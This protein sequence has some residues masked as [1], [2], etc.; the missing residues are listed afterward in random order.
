MTTTAINTEKVLSSQLSLTQ[1]RG[2]KNEVEHLFKPVLNNKWTGTYEQRVGNEK[3]KTSFSN[4]DMEASLRNVLAA[5]ET[6]MQPEYYHLIKKRSLTGLNKLLNRKENMASYLSAAYLYQRELGS[7]DSR[8]SLNPSIIRELTNHL[9]E[10]LNNYYLLD[11][12]AL[13]KVDG[14]EATIGEHRLFVDLA[15]KRT[16]KTE[17]VVKPGKIQNGRLVMVTD[18]K[19]E[20]GE[21][22]PAPNDQFKLSITHIEHSIQTDPSGI[23]ESYW[24][25]L[26][27]PFPFDV[28]FSGIS[29]PSREHPDDPVALSHRFVYDRYKDN[30]LEGAWSYHL[31]FKYAPKEDDDLYLTIQDDMDVNKFSGS[32][33]D[34]KRLDLSAVAYLSEAIDLY[35]EKEP[36]KIIDKLLKTELFLDK[37]KAMMQPLVDPIRFRYSENNKGW[38][39]YN[40]QWI[41]EE[42]YDDLGRRVDGR[43]TIRNSEDQRLT[44]FG[45]FQSVF[46]TIQVIQ[47]NDFGDNFRFQTDIVEFPGH[48]VPNLD[49][50][51]IE[52]TDE[53][54][55]RTLSG[56]D[57][58]SQI[59][60]TQQKMGSYTVIERMSYIKNG[61][62]HLLNGREIWSGPISEYVTDFEAGDYY[63]IIHFISSRD[64]FEEIF[65]VDF[66]HGD[67]E[68]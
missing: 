58:L 23:E 14:S 62:K 1:E 30:P 39:S 35:R 61:V 8:P 15:D 66:I 12:A 11:G 41:I 24:I 38:I 45:G 18:M 63:K 43:W 25:Q 55:I 46:S 53:N 2:I 5:Y 34:N 60:T 44:V 36:E 54:V 56:T 20:R 21:V 31:D 6:F 33:A 50:I 37:Y 19:N 16:S 52:D 17:I 3:V 22:D 29:R 7:T 28:K 48:V 64:G 57:V 68:K 65:Q 67:K 42:A 59:Q 9:Q 13:F 10:N 47:N 40:A 26:I 32:A 4:V 49:Y 27:E 51:N